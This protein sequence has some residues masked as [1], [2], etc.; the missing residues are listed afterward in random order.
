MLHSDATISGEHLPL[1]AALA[2]GAGQRAG[3]NISEERALEWLTINPARSLHLDK[4]IGSLE[5]GKNADVVLWSGDPFS[6][7]TRAEVVLIDGAVVYDRNDPSRQALSD[8]EV[9]Q[10]AIARPE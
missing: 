7:Y 2:I 3:V 6:V 1:D 8:F 9:G 5:P 10:P 4:Q